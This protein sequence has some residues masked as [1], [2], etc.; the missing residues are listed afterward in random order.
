M[1][2]PVN[3]EGQSLQ[4]WWENCIFTCQKKKK[5]KPLSCTP[6]SKINSKWIKDPNVK[7]ITLQEDNRG[8]ASRHWTWQLFLRYNTKSKGYKNKNRQ[9][10]HQPQILFVHQRTHWIERKGNLWKWKKTLAN[11]APVA[12]KYHRLGG[13]NNR[14]LFLI[15]LEGRKSKIWMPAWSGFWWGPFPQPAKG[16]SSFCTL[17]WPR[18]RKLWSLFLFLDLKGTNPIIGAPPSWITYLTKALLLNI[19]T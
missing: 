14:H 3:K 9:I 12:T 19:N 10:G 1:P 11:L 4:Q 16:L 15:V 17:T 6:H 13:L 5:V 2:R 7:P 18:E 8:K